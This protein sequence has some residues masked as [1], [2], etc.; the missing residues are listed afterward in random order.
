MGIYQ[1]YLVGIAMNLKRLFTSTAIAASLLCAGVANAE[2][3]QFSI[4]GD[5]TASWQLDT[6][7]APDLSL[8]ES[9]LTYFDVVGVFPNAVFDIADISF[10]HSKVGGG[11]SLDDFN[12]EQTLLIADG[13]QLYGGSED[14][15]TFT[16]GSYALTEFD[17]TG[18]YTLTISAVPE[19]ATYGMMLGGMALVGFAL[20]RRQAR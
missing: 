14:N 2:L 3:Y 1:N 8:P 19:P 5:Y 6:D 16:T 11:L 13:P 10:F 9:G 15:P 20:R 4:S 12:S 7:V 17:G 18:T